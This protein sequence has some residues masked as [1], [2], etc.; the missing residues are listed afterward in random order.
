MLLTGSGPRKEA[1]ATGAP[2]GGRRCFLRGPG[3]LAVRWTP[4]RLGRLASP[5]PDTHYPLDMLYADDL[6]SMEIPLS[7]L[8]RIGLRRA[9]GSV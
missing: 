2:G 1:P 5:V 7:Y 3:Y 4:R 8:F 9:A 6:E